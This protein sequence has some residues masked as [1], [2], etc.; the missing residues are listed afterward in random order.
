MY[1]YFCTHPNIEAPSKFV[2]RLQRAFDVIIMFAKHKKYQHFSVFDT[3][4]GSTVKEEDLNPR[5]QL[6]KRNW[7]VSVFFFW[8]KKKL[9]FTRYVR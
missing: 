8:K 4:S 3:A 9:Q 6:S 7:H 5:I 1:F 2:D